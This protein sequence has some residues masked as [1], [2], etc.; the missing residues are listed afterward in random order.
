MKRSYVSVLQIVLSGLILSSLIIAIGVPTQSVYA[1][2]FTVT[3]TADTNDGACN[4]DCSLREAITAANAAAGADTITL[5]AGTYQLTLANSGGANEDSNATGDLDILDSLTINGAGSGTTII[6][7]GTNTSDGIDK[8]IAANPFCTSG[9][10]VTIAGVTV[11]FGRNTQPTSDPN[12]SF[13]GGGIDWCAGGTGGTFTLSN[14]VISDNTNVNGYGGGLNVDTVSSPTTVNITNVT[15]SGNRTLST[16]NTATGGGINIF[17]DSPT[18]NITNS[19]FTSNLTTNATSGGGAIYFRP[20]TVGHLTISGSTFTSN[21]AAGIG[22]AI[23][24][25]AHGAGTTISISNS[26]F[27]GNTATNS[28]G[29]ALKLDGTNLNTT[30]FSLTH[31]KITG[32]TAGISGGGIFV[33]NSNVTMSQSLIV[34]NNAPTGKGIHKSVDAATATVTNNWWGCSTGPSAAPCD[35]ATTA[36]GALTFTPWYRNQL[37]ATTS[38]IV[39]NQSTALTASFLTNSANAAVPVADL[40]EIIGRSVTWA[41]THGTL[42]STQATVQAAGTATGSFQATAAGTAIISAKVD[43][44][45]TAPVSSNVLSLT[46]NKANT[47]AAITNGASLSSTPSVTGQPV[48]VTFSVTG[49]FGNSPTA[50]TG[51]VT[52]SDGTDSCTGTVAAGTCNLTFKTAG[53]KTLTATYAG[54]TNFNTSPAS[55]SASHTVNKADTTTTITSDNPDPSV[56][57]QTVTLNVTVAAVAPGAAVSPTTI[58]GSVTVSDGGINSCVVTLTAGAGSCTI[59]FPSTGPYSMTGSYAGDSN[60]NGS[61]S[62]AIS[63]TVN[64]ADTTTTITSDTPD[65]SDVG[66]AV[67]VNFTVAPIAPGAGTP[68]GNVTVSDGVDSCT[69]T[70]SAGTCNVSLTTPGARTL[71]ATYAGDGNFNGS[72]S[73]GEPH[74]VN[75]LATTTTITSDNPDPSVMGEAVTVQ[76]SVTTASGTPSGNVTVSDGTISCT[77]TVSAGQCSLSFTSAGAKS[78]TATYEGDATHDGSASAAEPHQVNAAD[79]TTTITSDNPDPSVVGESVTVQYNV[80][81]V[82]PGAGIPTGNVTVSDGT[83][84][85]TGTV[86]AGQ[87]SLTF[88]SAGAKSFTATYA[89]DSNFNGSTSAAEAHQ[90]NKADT[91]T[92]ITADNPDPSVLSQSVTV[93]YSVTVNAPGAGTPTGN[94]TVSD[95]VDSCTG[96]VAAGQCDVMLT[97]A[98]ARTLTATYAGDSNF[99]GSSSAG[100]PHTVN[101]TPTTTT[102]TSDNPDPSVVGQSVVVQYSVTSVSGTPTGNVTVSDGTISCTATV[103]AGQCSLTFTSAGAKSLTATY[104][105][106]GTFGGSTSTAEAHQVNLADTTTTITSDTPDPSAGGQSVTVQYNVTVNAPGAGIPTGNVTVSD[107]VDSCTGTVAAGQC[108]ITLT[109]GG[110][111][112]L[113]ATY[114]G[115]GNFNGSTSAGEPHTVDNTPPAVT[116][117]QAAGQADP[118]TSSP[119]NFEVVFSEAVSGFDSSDVVLSGTAGATS[120]VVT[121]IT[122]NNGTTYDVAVSGMS[123]S[124]TVIAS[125]PA[126]AVIDAAGNSNTASTSTDNTVTFVF[127]SPTTLLYNGAQIVN[128]GDSFQAA[129]KLSSAATACISGQTISFSLDVSPLDGSAGPYPLG[130][131]ITNSSGQATLNVSTSGWQEGIYVITATFAGTPGCDPSSDSAT[132]TVASPGNSATGGGWYTLS[133]SG[134]INFGFNVRK[135]DNKCKSNCEYKGNLLLMNNGK[136]KLRGSLDTYSKLSTGQGAASG[137]GDLYW[138]DSSL[139]GG[140]GDWALAQSGVAYTINFY[141]SGKKGKASTD[142]FG[143][144]IQYVPVLPQPSSL[145]NSSPTQLKGGD[146]KVQ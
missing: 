123:T 91:T 6:Q 127:T 49:T 82:A 105:G 25:D 131:A 57:G 1:A 141:D 63:H 124:G 27:T 15:F 60:F 136:W 74:S 86:A 21:T 30:P 132:L 48:A 61:T 142:A 34:G 71:T 75:K 120:A 51:N 2:T 128:V 84:S 101:G 38:P 129:A 29:G 16:V 112:I 100:E 79:T 42:S 64:K 76:Y 45:N 99:N 70:V 20:T 114:A 107:G 18:V 110:A 94:V 55:A 46:V 133:G 78:L 135:V 62:A 66:Q 103:A 50:P 95:G 36:G 54:D 53:A 37:T 52:V 104:A 68:A 126:N 4:V 43:N 83:I 3:K 26:T 7:A 56:T 89:G 111:R 41:A 10:N 140:L 22:G 144:N 145:P 116:I 59:A 118:T 40:A 33:G 23:A 81:P 67:T 122:P 125:I 106:D 24:T 73:A 138:W 130:D 98:G 87:C 28:F 117:N 12:F 9:V 8:V 92:S 47:T 5:P 72:T 93:Q 31:L 17:G 119:I 35:T 97:S 109:T 32:N 121:E 58:T 11:R 137:V 113:T 65:P 90:V 14:S 88:T 69:G 146:I 102:I 85:C 77:G 80:A 115:D 134:R 96:T 39:T 19:T 13:T 44:D 139:N 108:S 143:I